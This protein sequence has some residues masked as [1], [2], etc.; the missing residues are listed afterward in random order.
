MTR[1]ET[2]QKI[3]AYVLEEYLKPTLDRKN[4]QG[5]INALLI[6]PGESE[7]RATKKFLEG[8]RGVTKVNIFTLDLFCFEDY[9]KAEA[10]MI[11]YGASYAGA[12]E[13]YG[14][15]KCD[16]A[17]ARLLGQAELT[18]KQSFDLILIRHPQITINKYIYNEIDEGVAYYISKAHGYLKPDGRYFL[19]LLQSGEINDLKKVL[20][21]ICQSSGAEVLVAKDTDVLEKFYEENDIFV[22][23]TTGPMR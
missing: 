7:I 3:F 17:Y 5:E 11:S 6:G 21:R 19:T 10:R 8:L 20:G 23:V 15:A 18:E 2:N 9:R 4:F 22:A 13:T 12:G 16:E 1:S 14:D